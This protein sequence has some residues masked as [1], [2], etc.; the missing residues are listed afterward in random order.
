MLRLAS[1][2]VSRVTPVMALVTCLT[3]GLSLTGCASD[4]PMEPAEDANDPACAEVI[5]RLPQ[6]I[7]GLEK[8]STNAQ[9]TGAWGDPVGIQLVCG[10]PLTAPTTDE[11]VSVNGVDWTIDNSQAPLYRFDAYGRS[12][13]LA[14]FVNSELASGTEAVHALESV[15]QILP[16]TRKCTSVSDSLNL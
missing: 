16:Q 13:G 7:G 3:L 8:R 6:T 5:V 14:V 9:S 10:T 4:V 2:P 15:T 1:H 11:C 12:P